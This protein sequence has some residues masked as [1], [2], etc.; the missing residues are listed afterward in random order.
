MVAAQ[1]KEK[2]MFVTGSYIQLLM[3][4][5]SFD[6]NSIPP[7]LYSLGSSAAFPAYGGCVCVLCCAGC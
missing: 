2:R 6:A 1:L 3:N 4:A 7:Y 5:V